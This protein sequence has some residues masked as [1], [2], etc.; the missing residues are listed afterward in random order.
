MNLRR[1]LARL[2]K[3][4]FSGG[5]WADLVASPGNRPEE[6]IDAFHTMRSRG[7]R[8]RYRVVGIGG[9]PGAPLGSVAQTVKVEVHRDD[10]RRA[11]EA[12]EDMRRNDQ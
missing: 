6:A 8:V 9:G 12:L 7:I 3:R 10:L 5:T 11:H 4:L 1:H 2:F